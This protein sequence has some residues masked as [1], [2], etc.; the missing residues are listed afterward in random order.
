MEEGAWIGFHAPRRSDD[1]GFL[2]DSAGSA[3]VGAYLNELGLPS[4]A[5]EYMTER[6]PVDMNWLSFDDADRLGIEIQE[7]PSEFRGCFSRST[8]QGN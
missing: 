5:I 7:L 8:V 6:Q 1:P 4:R 2:P 3:V